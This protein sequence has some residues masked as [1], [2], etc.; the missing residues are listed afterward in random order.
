MVNEL[1]EK[2]YELDGNL[3]Q[4]AICDPCCGTGNFLLSLGAKGVNCLNL[5]G[6][7]IDPISVYLCRI[8]IALIE[9]QISATDLRSRILIG[10]TFFETFKQ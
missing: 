1:I 5:Y 10:N 7:D 4:K 8:N 2:L 6:Q 3:N 9:P